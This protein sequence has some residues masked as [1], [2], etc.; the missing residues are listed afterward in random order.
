SATPWRQAEKPEA[1]WVVAFE[2]ND[3][4]RTPRTSAPVKLERQLWVERVKS[5]AVLALP[6]AVPREQRRLK[7]PRSSGCLHQ[8]SCGRHWSYSSWAAASGC[9][10]PRVGHNAAAMSL[11]SSGS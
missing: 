8:K 6:E 7:P 1:C 11:I 10:C 4:W 3:V 5:C 2:L 9:M